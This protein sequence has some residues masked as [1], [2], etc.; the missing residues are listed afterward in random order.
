MAEVLI[1]D[2]Q[3]EAGAIV[4]REIADLL[5]DK[6][7]AV[8]GV[9]TGSTPLAVYRALEQLIKD[10]G[11]DVSQ[12]RAFA[13]DEYVEIDPNHPESYRSVIHREVTERL[14]LNPE[15]VLVPGQNATSLAT[16]GQEYDAA[17]EAAG[18]VDVQI[19][20]IGRTGHIGFNEPGSSLASGTRIKTLAAA[21]RR[22]NARFFDSEDEVP[23]H[24][25]TQGIGTILKARHL[26]LLAFGE[27]KADALAASIEGPV[28][29][30]CTGSAIQLHPRA[31]VIADEAAAAKFDNAEYYRFAAANKPDWQGL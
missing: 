5:K 26:F 23:I 21:T 1:V 12:V 7:D 16:A 31:T 2:S 20:G 17:I 29:A 9:A 27:S 13:L 15:Y 8:L 28:T 3:D 24:C 4:A 19:L 25:I 14:G 22:D 11:I 10:E 18:G 30:S 6:P